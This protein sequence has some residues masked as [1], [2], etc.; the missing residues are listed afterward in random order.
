MHSKF[1]IQNFKNI[2]LRI[3]TVWISHY[4]FYIC[5]YLDQLTPTLTN[6]TR[7]PVKRVCV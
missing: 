2:I 7:Q 1:L 6:L 3:C 4:F 5:E